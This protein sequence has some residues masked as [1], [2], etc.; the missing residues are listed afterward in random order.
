MNI[1][2]H[3]FVSNFLY[4]FHPVTPALYPHCRLLNSAGIFF[5]QANCLLHRFNV[6]SN[7]K[8]E[9]Q[10]VVRPLSLFVWSP[11]SSFAKLSRL[12][13]CAPYH[14][15]NVTQCKVKRWCHAM[16]TLFKNLNGS[17]L[18]GFFNFHF[19][20]SSAFFA[21]CCQRASTSNNWGG[22]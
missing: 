1:F 10:L 5:H 20:D 22:S 13:K 2:G 17:V 12:I 16:M 11:P 3:L 15:I 7:D 4:S 21:Q 19:Y 14:L 18:I 6:Q 9:E 8:R